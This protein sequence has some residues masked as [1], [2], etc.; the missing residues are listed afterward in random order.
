MTVIICAGMAPVHVETVSM[1]KDGELEMKLQLA[2]E[3]L[4]QR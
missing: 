3:L 4:P 2:L 1:E